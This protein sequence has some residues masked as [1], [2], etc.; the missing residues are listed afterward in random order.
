MVINVFIFDYLQRQLHFLCCLNEMCLIAVF[1]C[2]L[3]LMLL[4]VLKG[5]FLPLARLRITLCDMQKMWDNFYSFLPAIA[6][7][8][9][10]L[11][12]LQIS[13]TYTMKTRTIQGGPEI[14]YA[15]INFLDILYRIQNYTI[16]HWQTKAFFFKSGTIVIHSNFIQS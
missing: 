6:Q 11:V 10:P 16:Q 12:A 8:T 1:Q 9:Y 5:D 2:F 15:Q 14:T 7:N 3:Q 4:Q 13:Y